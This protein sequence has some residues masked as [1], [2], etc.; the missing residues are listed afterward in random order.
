M[1]WRLECDRE[2][3]TLSWRT[4][5][6]PENH[7]PF[8]EDRIMAPKTKGVCRMGPSLVPNETLG[9]RSGAEILC[10][11]TNSCICK[12]LS[13]LSPLY[14]PI[15]DRL[16]KVGL[17]R[18]NTERCHSQDERSFA[19]IREIEHRVAGRV[20]HQIACLGLV[21]RRQPVIQAATGL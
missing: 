18:C 20:E 6:W 13:R 12:P 17:Q 5:S 14:L 11:I 21:D 4:G 3:M 19:R 15:A 16:G 7:D 9:S 2:I 1:R 10:K 8:L